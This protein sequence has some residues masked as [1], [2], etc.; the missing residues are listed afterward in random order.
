MIKLKC[1]NTL[2]L[3]IAYD[4]PHCTNVFIKRY[5]L[6]NEKVIIVI[7]LSVVCDKNKLL[8]YILAYDKNIALMCLS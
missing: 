3:I 6:R 4:K 5:I 2:Y 7:L 1:L 8:K